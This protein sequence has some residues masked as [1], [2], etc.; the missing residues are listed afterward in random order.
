[1]CLLLVAPSSRGCILCCSADLHTHQRNFALAPCACSAVHARPNSG[2][3]ANHTRVMQGTSRPALRET[4]ESQSFRPGRGT[5]GR[6]DHRIGGQP[7]CGRRYKQGTGAT[8]G[9]NRW[10]SVRDVESSG[11]TKPTPK[12]RWK[13]GPI[14]PT[15]AVGSASHVQWHQSTSMNAVGGGLDVCR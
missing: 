9:A 5:S 8:V 6:Q 4:A 15:R 14:S 7:T 12:S 3:L 13:S 1:V 2:G 11:G 10:H